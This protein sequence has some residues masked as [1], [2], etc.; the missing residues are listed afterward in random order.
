MM[1]LIART[2]N[3]KK[4]VWGMRNIVRSFL[5]VLVFLWYIQVENLPGSSVFGSDI[6]DSGLGWTSGPGWMFGGSS[7]CKS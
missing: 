2:E 1:A 5:E 7:V 3:P 6:Q 4:W